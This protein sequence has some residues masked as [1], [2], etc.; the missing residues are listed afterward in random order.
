MSAST[1]YSRI[2][3]SVFF[4]WNE[5]KKLKKVEELEDVCDHYLPSKALLS[6]EASG[7]WSFLR[8]HTVEV[9]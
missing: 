4:M 2:G 9:Y 1:S 5:K 6:Q 3:V 8:P 7:G